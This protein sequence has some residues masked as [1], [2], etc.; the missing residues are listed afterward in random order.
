MSVPGQR[1]QP[2]GRLVPSELDEIMIAAV[3]DDFY[4]KAR[5]DPLL[6]PIFTRVIPD[7]EWRAHM[8][9]IADFWSSLLLGTRRYEGRPMPKHLA[10]GDLDDNHFER[11]LALFRETAESLCPPEIAALFVDRAERI[12][13][14]FR[15]GLAFHRGQ[16]TINIAPMRA[17]LPGHRGRSSGSSSS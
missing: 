9:V 2:S 3:V 14:S 15:L 16:D 10:I 8:D 6:G 17:G 11:W 1:L 7:A 12:A 13:H 4:A 5:V